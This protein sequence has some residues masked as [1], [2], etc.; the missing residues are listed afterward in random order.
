M[1]A[2]TNLVKS[3]LLALGLGAALAAPAA[4]QTI[5]YTGGGSSALQGSFSGTAISLGAIPTLI[6]TSTAANPVTGFPI[7]ANSGILESNVAI[8]DPTN[9]FTESVTPALVLYSSTDGT[10]GNT[11]III[12]IRS[13][14]GYGV[15]YVANTE[16][17]TGWGTDGA[18][19]NGNFASFTAAG[20]FPA[21]NATNN[22]APVGLDAAVGAYL[23]GHTGAAETIYNGLSDVAADTIVTYV[24]NQFAASPIRVAGLT[25]VTR[26]ALPVQ[27]LLFLYNNTHSTA[28][29][30]NVTKTQA[31]S[32]IGGLPNSSTQAS[33]LTWGKIVPAEAGGALDVA[34]DAY[35]REEGSGTR[36][37][38]LLNVQ[39]YGVGTPISAEA[40]TYIE[41]QFAGDPATQAVPGNVYANGV[42]A[43]NNAAILVNGAHTYYSNGTG[44]MV[45]ALNTDTSAFGYAFITGTAAAGKTNVLV[46]SYDGVEPYSFADAASN[47]GAAAGTFGNEV[48]SAGYNYPAAATSYYTNTVNGTY[49]LWAFGNQYEAPGSPQAATAS[50]I[51]GLLD[52]LDPA[53]TV[54]ALGLARVSEM[55]VTRVARKGINVP[56]DT[57]QDGQL[58]TFDSLASKPATG[59]GTS[60]NF[61]TVAKKNS[62]IE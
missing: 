54:D 21:Y 31:R 11:N 1:T 3:S 62:A 45:S 48:P 51:A 25:G 7:T 41:N 53:N 34:V 10:I 52:T 19:T 43:N 27:T 57:V 55:K 4:A 16:Q 5:V 24:P 38:E 23:V 30:L 33:S 29:A 35:F 22:A 12:L 17:I 37:T 50:S 26:D 56:A 28:E 46:A 39:R 18:A 61:N 36:N 8:T 47:F 40:F 2:R 15:R 32:L 59:N 44:G 14:S 58:I 49:E 20:G 60:K 9:A 13:D 42:T 6:V